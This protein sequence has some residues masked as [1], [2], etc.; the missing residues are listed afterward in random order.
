M[1]KD[2]QTLILQGIFQETLKRK[3]SGNCPFCSE[4][5]ISTASY[6]TTIAHNNI[7]LD[8]QSKWFIHTEK[9]SQIV[10]LIYFSCA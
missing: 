10:L 4:S 2:T 8:E 5:T 6:A 1:L 9:Q 7:L 3:L